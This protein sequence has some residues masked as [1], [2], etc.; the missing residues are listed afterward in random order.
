[1][2]RSERESVREKGKCAHM[3]ESE[4][5]HTEYALKEAERERERE[6]ERGVPEWFADQCLY[7]LCLVS[8]ASATCGSWVVVFRGVLSS[9]PPFGGVTRG[10]LCNGAARM[11]NGCV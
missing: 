9:T 7:C 10:A 11:E 5:A 2:K 8:K 1:V 4:R 6:R 3:R